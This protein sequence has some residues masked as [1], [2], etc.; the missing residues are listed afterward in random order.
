MKVNFD[1][2][3]RLVL[4]PT[5]EAALTTFVN[6]PGHSAEAAAT[7]REF[8]QNRTANSGEHIAQLTSAFTTLLST[9]WHQT[10]AELV[11]RLRALMGK[12]DIEVP[13][14]GVVIPG[15]QSTQPGLEPVC[16]PAPRAPTDAR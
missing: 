12:S 9:F 7:T 11:E 1:E 5:E 2:K 10:A 8:L 13:D 15:T 16:P 3:N 6:T 14:G 4:D